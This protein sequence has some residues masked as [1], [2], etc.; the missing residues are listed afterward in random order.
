MWRLIIRVPLTIILQLQ[1]LFSQNK[2]FTRS[3][4]IKHFNN[5]IYDNDII[6]IFTNIIII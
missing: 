6:Q 1:I 2:I 5:K 4:K 3:L